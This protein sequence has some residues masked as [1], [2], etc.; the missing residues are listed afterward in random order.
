MMWFTW[1]IFT[2]IVGIIVIEI[3][4]RCTTARNPFFPTLPFHYSECTYRNLCL[5]Q[6]F[7][8][9]FHYE[10]T[11]VAFHIHLRHSSL[12]LSF[13]ENLDMS[14]SE[15]G[16]KQ[17]PRFMSK[18]MKVM[19]GAYGALQREKQGRKIEL[20][21]NPRVVHSVLVFVAYNENYKWMKDG[22]KCCERNYFLSIFF[23]W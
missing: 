13:T 15:F 9:R 4:R 21:C 20:C 11:A 23:C 1:L 7:L 14:P 6:L 3:F 22:V 8:I 17:N 12:T 5:G 18:Y 2:H 16:V 10:I 19:W